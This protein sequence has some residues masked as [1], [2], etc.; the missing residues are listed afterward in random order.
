MRHR[1]RT[2]ENQRQI[3]GALRRMGASVLHLHQ[4]G[5]GAPDIVIGYRGINLLV[6]IKHQR[7]K[8]T[9]DEQTFADTWRGNVAI[10]RDVDEAIKL[11][12]ALM[13]SN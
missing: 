10:V 7:G 4:L 11:L 3:V 13:P 2:D 8:L 6:E 1:A 9:E 5:H 12:S